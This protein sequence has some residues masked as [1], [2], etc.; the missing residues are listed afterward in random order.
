[1][2]SQVSGQPPPRPPLP[3]PPDLVPG[4]VRAR[5]LLRV[6]KVGT[7][8][9]ALQMPALHWPV[10]QSSFLLLQTPGPLE[11]E[12]RMQG[13]L[14]PTRAVGRREGEQTHSWQGTWEAGRCAR[15]RGSNETLQNLG[16]GAGGP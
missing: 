9:R 16:G 1:M 14:P 3:G 15:T 12:S 7:A 4:P 5:D 8:P 10:P 6:S 2:V 11:G 13:C